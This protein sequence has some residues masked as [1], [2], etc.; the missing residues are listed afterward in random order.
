MPTER[1]T[2]GFTA[3]LGRES[4][5]SAGPPARS[6]ERFPSNGALSDPILADERT[7]PG[8]RADVKGHRATGAQGDC[9]P[10]YPPSSWVGVAKTRGESLG[11]GA[12]RCASGHFKVGL[13]DLSPRSDISASGSPFAQHARSSARKVE[14]ISPGAPDVLSYPRW[15]VPEDAGQSPAVRSDA[16]VDPAKRAEFKAG[17]ATGAQGDR[18]PT[19]PT[20]FVAKTRGESLGW[21]AVR[22]TPGKAPRSISKWASMTLPLEGTEAH[23]GVRSR[24][25]R[26][27]PRAE[28]NGAPRARPTSCPIRG[29]TFPKSKDA[30]QSPAVRPI[31]TRFRARRRKGRPR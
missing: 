24:S 13:H 29:G 14:R 4:T 6:S 30:G 9:V 10:T 7:A 15:H 31:S 28:S 25:M 8:I 1:F 2:D 20:R 19:Y 27:T 16:R 3:P 12:I 26:G 23:R 5:R 11:W 21:G 18:V 22:G 17:C